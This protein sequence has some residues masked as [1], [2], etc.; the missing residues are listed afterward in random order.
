VAKG[1]EEVS[2]K[3]SVKVDVRGLEMVQ[4]FVKLTQKF[5]NDERVPVNVREEFMDE[6]DKFMDDL[7]KK[8]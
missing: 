7:T 4:D 8:G 5:V 2:G 6:F 3:L 1:V